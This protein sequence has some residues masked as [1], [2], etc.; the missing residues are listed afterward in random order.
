MCVRVHL[1]SYPAARLLVWPAGQPRT[2]SMFFVFL[3]SRFDFFHASINSLAQQ[4]QQQHDDRLVNER[5]LAA[6]QSFVWRRRRR[7]R[8]MKL[9]LPLGARNVCARAA[10]A[11]P[12]DSMRELISRSHTMRSQRL[13]APVVCVCVASTAIWMRHCCVPISAQLCAARRTPPARCDAITIFAIKT[14]N[15][16]ARAQ[17][18]QQQ[19]RCR[20]LN[21]SASCALV[22]R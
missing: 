5:A 13:G 8:R 2:C 11:W 20:W 19:C 3:R 4:Q 14:T 21:G 10:D 7:R 22:A 1:T 9:P 17:C 15:F 16:G 12:H 18:R 6:K